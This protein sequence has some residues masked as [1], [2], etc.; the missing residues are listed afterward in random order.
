MIFAHSSVEEEVLAEWV[1]KQEEVFRGT[2]SE[3]PS[4]TSTEAS[5]KDLLEQSIL[6]V[7]GQRSSVPELFW[8]EPDSSRMMPS[9]VRHKMYCTI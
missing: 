1:K 2:Q 3:D 9:D 7:P 8:M 6:D 4:K 5:T